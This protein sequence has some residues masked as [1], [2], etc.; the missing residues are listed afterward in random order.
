MSLATSYRF[1]VNNANKSLQRALRGQRDRVEA[2][3]LHADR[4]RGLKRDHEI[5]LKADWNEKLEEVAG[6][7]RLTE[8]FKTIKEEVRLGRKAALA[9]RQEA[10]RQQLQQERTMFQSELNTAGK[11]FYFQRI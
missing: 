1:E 11:T 4:E 10:L 5:T 8:S 7:K 9:V 2:E 3:E 6:R